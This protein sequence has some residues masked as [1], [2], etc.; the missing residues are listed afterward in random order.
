MIT[1][2]PDGWFIE[3][4]GRYYHLNQKWLDEMH[5]H[6]VKPYGNN[7]DYNRLAYIFANSSDPDE[8]LQAFE[9]FY[10][11]RK[12]RQGR[13]NRS[14]E[15]SEFQQFIQSRREQRAADRR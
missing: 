3:R 13:K 10:D 6:Q 7:P 11:N 4:N 14:A 2:A 12:A 1:E 5:R 8:V 15:P 9:D